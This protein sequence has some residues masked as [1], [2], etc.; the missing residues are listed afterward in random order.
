MKSQHSNENIVSDSDANINYQNIIP[1][2]SALEESRIS[3]SSIIE[4]ISSIFPNDADII[5]VEDIILR[6]GSKIKIIYTNS[7]KYIGEADEFNRINGFGICEYR[8]NNKYIG[9]YLEGKFHGFGKIILSN[10]ETLQ[11][12]FFNNEPSGFIEHLI[13]NVSIQENISKTFTGDNVKIYTKIDSKDKLNNICIEGEFDAKNEYY[14]VGILKCLGKN[15]G[16]EGEFVNFLSKGWG[17]VT[18]KDKF[19]HKGRINLGKFN[20]YGEIYYPEGSRLFCFFEGNNKHGLSISTNSEGKVSFGRYINNV[21]HGPFISSFKNLVVVELYN[22]GFKSRIF[23]R[24]ESAKSYFKQFYPEYDWVLKVNV[25]KI[26][27]YFS[28]I[29]AEEYTVPAVPEERSLK[30]KYKDNVNKVNINGVVSE[31]KE[32]SLIQRIRESMKRDVESA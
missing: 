21:K 7:F 8:N 31:K 26:V 9:K 12:E 25:K 2:T 27:E 17:I 13:N 6:N 28:E 18:V 19:I 11:G 15:F 30:K 5:S 4:D 14:G 23:E 22:H 20:G 10:G 24:L 16:Y 32:I 1:R 3:T 29:R